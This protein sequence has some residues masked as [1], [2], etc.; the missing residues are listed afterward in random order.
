MINIIRPDF[1]M[2]ITGQEVIFDLFLFLLTSQNLT[3]PED[4]LDGFRKRESCSF[5]IFQNEFKEKDPIGNDK[6]Y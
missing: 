4:E 1:E 2:V 3:N 6:K 5:S